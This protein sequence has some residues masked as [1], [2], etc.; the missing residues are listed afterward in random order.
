MV[1]VSNGYPKPQNIFFHSTSFS[2]L[3]F[4]AQTVRLLV[5]HKHLKPAA[6]VKKNENG[7]DFEALC[8]L[9]ACK[10]AQF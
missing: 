6:G 2:K 1:N 10:T 9:L 3:F 5:C 4:F 8:A 7:V